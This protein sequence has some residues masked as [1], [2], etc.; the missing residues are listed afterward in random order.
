MGRPD[1]YYLINALLLQSAYSGTNPD[2]SWRS[3]PPEPGP[4]G[5]IHF[6]PPASAKDD[7]PRF[8]NLYPLFTHYN[9]ANAAFAD[10]ASGHLLALLIAHRILGKER[11]QLPISPSQYTEW[12][13]ELTPLLVQSKTYEIPLIRMVLDKYDLHSADIPL[14]VNT[15]RSSLLAHFF[16]RQY[17]LNREPVK[18]AVEPGDIVIEGGMGFGDTAL[19]FSWQV[20][21]QGR[22]IGFEFEPG[23]LAIMRD[24]FSFNPEY[25]GRIEVL[26]RALS[27]SSDQDMRFVMGGPATQP[28][29][30]GVDPNL[31]TMTV[32]TITID[33]V[34]QQKNLPKVDF[35]KLDVEGCEMATLRGATDTLRRFKPKL[36]LSAYHKVDDVPRMIDFLAGLQLGYQFWLDHFRYYN[37]ETVLFARTDQR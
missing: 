16:L 18:I 11:V 33:D 30:K 2:G 32:K 5:V 8:T 4:D 17:E 26:E 3:G 12:M 35:I 24:N 1:F 25:A 13:N 31:Q 29:Y 37:Q 15:T 10:D 19:L 7:V 20:G 9:R 21:E 34:V 23:N 36:A 14:R 6:S 28:V 22:I 27:D